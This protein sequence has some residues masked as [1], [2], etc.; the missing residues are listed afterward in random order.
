MSALCQK[1]TLAGLFDHLVGGHEQAGRYGQPE[2]LRRFEIEGGFE[3]SRCLHRKVG[4]LVAA[5]DT[6]DIGCSLPAHVNE[7]N[8]VGHETPEVTKT[9]LL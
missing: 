9:R 8:P 3:L 2:R 5:Q 6:V 4:R 7:V 1:Q